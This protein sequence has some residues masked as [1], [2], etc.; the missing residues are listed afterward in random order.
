MSRAYIYMEH[1]DT[2]MTVTL[3]RLTVNQGVGEFVYDPEYVATGGWVPDPIRYPLRAEPF[4]NIQKNRGT[5]GFI[6]DAMPDGWGE[7]VINNLNSAHQPSM[8]PVDYLLR[9]PNNDRAGNLMAGITRHPSPGVGNEAIPTLSGL[10]AFIEAAEA[11]YD[12]ELTEEAIETLKLRRQRSSLGGARPKRT[13]QDEHVLILVKPRDRYDVCDT[14]ALE[15]ACMTFAAL[16]GINVS[17]TALYPGPPSTLL[18]KRFDRT[19]L[20][21]PRRIPMLSALTLLDAE[22]TTNDRSGWSYA[23]LAD[24]MVRRGLP[25]QDLQ[26]LFKRMC[27]NALV[28]NDDDHPKNHAIIWIRDSWR[29]APLYDVVPCMDG[30]SPAYLSMAL[31][32]EGRAIT[33]RNILSYCDH[34]MLSVE[35]ATAVLDEVA[36]WETGLRT[37]YRERLEGTELELALAAIGAHRLA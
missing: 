5:P 37:H 20:D 30:S 22:W 31:G 8:G 1:P 19:P 16:K 14:P 26:E 3:G 6:N 21:L 12:N 33:R 24:E 10:A 18:V 27:F 23:I 29:L 32:R 25:A 36:G 13:L 11:V 35:A 17:R 7:R 4:Q 28:G 15:H 2:G 34:F 9:S